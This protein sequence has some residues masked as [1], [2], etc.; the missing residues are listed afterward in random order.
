MLQIGICALAMSH[1][2]QWLNYSLDARIHK[3]NF[4]QWTMRRMPHHRAT[5]CEM[6][7]GSL[8]NHARRKTKCTRNSSPRVYFCFI[9]T[10]L[11]F[12]T[13]GR[14]LFYVLSRLDTYFYAFSRVF[15]SIL[16]DLTYAFTLLVG[17]FTL[18]ST[19]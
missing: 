3:S 16:P 10:D 8:I 4:R 1:A 12:S 18:F 15:S 11:Y 17:C 14:I 6:A 7:H 19:D 5:C 9:P 2:G 13:S